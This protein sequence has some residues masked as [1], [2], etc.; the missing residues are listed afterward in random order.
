MPC[1]KE[2]KDN[3]QSDDDSSCPSGTESM[4]E[5]DRITLAVEREICQKFDAMF[6][7]MFIV[8]AQ[9]EWPDRFLFKTFTMRN[10]V[11]LVGAIPTFVD[12]EFGNDLLVQSMPVLEAALRMVYILKENDHR[13][14][15]A[16]TKIRID[17][18]QV[19]SLLNT[20]VRGYI[21][22]RQH[23]VD[24]MSSIVEKRVQQRASQKEQGA[25]HKEQGASH[26]EP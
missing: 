10:R 16:P 23:G 22:D 21:V 13:N 24:V 11:W 18:A 6:T 3:Q 20:T 12:S 4:D 2:E 14:G 15:K 26:K 8:D 1:D 17:R 19:V 9:K 7:N 25:S 5:E